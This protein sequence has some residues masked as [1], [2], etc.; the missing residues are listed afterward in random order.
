MPSTRW[1]PRKEKRT[2]KSK[3][4]QEIKNEILKSQKLYGYTNEELNEQFDNG[5]YSS[6]AFYQFANLHKG[7]WTYDARFNKEG[8]LC[9]SVWKY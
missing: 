5:E 1:K 9:V 4:E 3:I 7:N 6:Q 8:E 2:M